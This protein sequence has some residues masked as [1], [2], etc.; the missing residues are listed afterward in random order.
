[1]IFYRIKDWERHFETSETRKTKSFSKFVPMPNRFDSAG[2]ASFMC[3]PEAERLY[4][5]WVVVVSVASRCS[6]RGTLVRGDGKPHTPQTL[7]AISRFKPKTFE[8]LFSHAT[9][10]DV[11]WLEMLSDG[12]PADTSGD[13][14]TPADTSGHH[15][16]GEERRGEEKRGDEKRVV[17]CAETCGDAGSAPDS[18]VMVFPCDGSPNEWKLMQSRVSKLQSLYPSLDVLMEC[19]K[20]LQYV[21]DKPSRKKT[22]KGMAAYLTGWMNRSQNWGGGSRA[23]PVPKSAGGKPSWL[24]TEGEDEA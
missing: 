21:E 9:T 12:T 16:R 2:Y 20:A 10:E 7:S 19:R 8:I 22:T 13:Q 5:A 18:V 11:D 14:R 17:T 3:H 15:P 6:P 1:M 24:T 23:G 4:G